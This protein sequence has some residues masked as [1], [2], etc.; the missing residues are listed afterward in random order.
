MFLTETDLINMKIT[1]AARINNSNII[2]DLIKDD[3]LSAQKERMAEG[4]K[5]YA[6]ENDVLKKDFRKAYIAEGESD[7]RDEDNIAYRAFYNP[8][9]SNHHNVNNFHETLV[10]QKSAYLV[11]R[12]PTITVKDAEKNSAA[13]A[14]E[15]LITGF[16]DEDFND[17]LN[18]LVIGASNKGIEVIHFYYNE[19]AELKYCIVPANECIP[20]YDTAY[21]NELVE[22]IRYYGI[23]VLKGEEKYKRKRVEWWT[24]TDVTYY[25]EDENGF[26]LLD[27]SHPINPAPHWFEVTFIND[28]QAHKEPH[29]WGR[30]PFVILKNNTKQTSDLQKVKSLIDAY[31]LIS[32]QGTNDLLDL[33][34]LYWSIQGYGGEAASAIAKKLQINR[35]VNVS[36][37][38]G[39]IN[40]HQID[41]PVAGRV[42]WL[43]MLR[44]DIFHFGMGVDTDNDKLGN[45][46]GVSLKFQ[47]TQLDLKANAMVPKLKKAIKEMLWFFT[48]D[49]NRTNGTDYNADD[50]DVTI[51][52]T[53]IT[54]DAETVS[55][56]TQSKGIVSDKTLLEH[57][58]F[59]DDANA[60]LKELEAQEEKEMKKYADYAAANKQI[61]PDGGGDK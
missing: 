12:E 32:S 23:T 16:A 60:E 24:K 19:D 40:A 30:V 56:I 44:R 46:S 47:Y 3:V 14:Y 53:M 41:L 25:A 27:G 55:M 51:N 29:S 11:S 38:Q 7:K 31:D 50:I 54:N 17:K 18:E 13:K 5:Y 39:S 9:R 33:V 37:A 57:H 20:V 36:D 28:K 15:T 21:Q 22:F 42:E 49:Y 8:G 45:A 61:T 6:G 52:K 10:D 26:F 34:T 4:E 58:P 35:A 48:D 2:R 43:K 1:I 59:V